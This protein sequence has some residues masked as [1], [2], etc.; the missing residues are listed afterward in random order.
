MSNDVEL[1][2]ARK[3][4]DG[5]GAYPEN[6]ER[7]RHNQSQPYRKQ[8]VQWIDEWPLSVP[9]TAILGAIWGDMHGLGVAQ[10]RPTLVLTAA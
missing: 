5:S 10:T 6:C 2:L 4:C 8:S 9:H 7:T 3:P 1:S